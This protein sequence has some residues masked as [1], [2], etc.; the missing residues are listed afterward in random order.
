VSGLSMGASSRSIPD[1]FAQQ[2]PMPISK[3]DAIGS[4]SITGNGNSLS[5]KKRQSIEP[6]AVRHQRSVAVCVPTTSYDP[7]SSPMYEKRCDDF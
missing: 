2:I 7:L 5:R 1:R 6:H 3:S 4:H